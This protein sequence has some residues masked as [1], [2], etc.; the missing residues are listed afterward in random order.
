MANE[1]NLISIGERTTREQ[2]EICSKGGRKSGEVRRKRKAIA[3]SLNAFGETRASKELVEKI[4]NET[5]YK[6]GVD[7][8]TID[9]LVVFRLYGKMLDGDIR[10]MNTFTRLMDENRLN[11]EVDENTGNKFAEVLEMWEKNRTCE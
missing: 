2:R 4:E 7:N 11:L 3:D 8:L 6:L 10:A 1:K 9:D 5:G